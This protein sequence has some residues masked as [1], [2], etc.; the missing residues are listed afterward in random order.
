MA[1]AANARVPIVT[2]AELTGVDVAQIRRWAEID[3]LEIQRR[4]G[5]ELVHLDRV[6][7]LSAA[8]RRRGSRSSRSTLRARLADA[9]SQKATVSGVEEA[10]RDHSDNGAQ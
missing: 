2:A 3:G 10:V 5:V 6:V 9:A 8:A 7:A 4:G 1:F